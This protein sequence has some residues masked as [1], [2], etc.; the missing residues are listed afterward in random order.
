MVLPITPQAPAPR[1]SNILK[2]KVMLSNISA[3]REKLKR[4]TAMILAH[5]TIW[6]ELDVFQRFVSS[7]L[8]TT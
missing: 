8:P 3:I 1:P 2:P 6:R 5:L 4:S 7:M